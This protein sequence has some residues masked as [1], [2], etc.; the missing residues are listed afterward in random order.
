M[1]TVSAATWANL[2]NMILTE[3]GD[4]ILSGGDRCE[5]VFRGFLRGQ[6]VGAGVMDFLKEG[7]ARGNISGRQQ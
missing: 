7:V 1:L 2:T 5:K 4:P 3:E 6:R